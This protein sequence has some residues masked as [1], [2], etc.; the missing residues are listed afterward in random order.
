MKWALLCNKICWLTA[1]GLSSGVC[2]SPDRSRWQWFW[3]PAVSLPLV[4]VRTWSAQRCSEGRSRRKKWAGCCLGPLVGL[5]LWPLSGPSVCLQDSLLWP[6]KQS[7]TSHFKAASLI[8]R[9]SIL[10]HL[11]YIYS[12]YSE[13][14]FINVSLYHFKY[15]KELL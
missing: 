10:E 5:Q 12:R 13:K 8:W 6:E 1:A 14:Y 15:H 3:A 9:P 4:G 11:M 2:V 7:N